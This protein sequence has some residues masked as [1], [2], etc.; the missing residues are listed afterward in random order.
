MTFATTRPHLTR[1]WRQHLQDGH[2]LSTSEEVFI[3]LDWNVLNYNEI[4]II[5]NFDWWRLYSKNCIWGWSSGSS[6]CRHD[7]PPVAVITDSR[8]WRSESHWTILL[9]SATPVQLHHAHSVLEIDYG[10]W[11]HYFQNGTNKTNYYFGNSFF[12]KIMC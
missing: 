12:V 9:Y 7:R 11:W 10:S 8:L 5:L 2:I 1:Q 3:Y 6:T 4:I